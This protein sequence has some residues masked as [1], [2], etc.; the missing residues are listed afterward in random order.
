[1]KEKNMTAT[2][3]SKLTGMRIVTGTSMIFEDPLPG[4]HTAR[5]PLAGC[6]WIETGEGLVVVDREFL[7]SREE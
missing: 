6:A 4:V 7:K 5:I 3:K 2:E 1:M